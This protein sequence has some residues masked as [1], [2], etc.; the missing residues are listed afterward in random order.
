MKHYGYIMEHH[1]N[2]MKHHWNFMDHHRNLRHNQP[3]WLPLIFLL[4]RPGVIVGSFRCFLI[5]KF[6]GAT[7]PS[8]LSLSFALWVFSRMRMFSVKA[9]AFHT[10]CCIKLASSYKTLQEWSKMNRTRQIFLIF[11]IS[12]SP[13][14]CI[15]A[16][17]KHA[18]TRCL[19]QI[20]SDISQI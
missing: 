20:W 3:L 5:L 11:M 13:I 9:F 8:G 12:T 16:Q 2:F 18:F 6:E 10:H 15:F 14:H 17:N 7:C 19:S 4:F 1:G